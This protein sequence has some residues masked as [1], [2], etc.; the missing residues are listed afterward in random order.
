MKTNNID[1]H[2]A[3]E[4]EIRYRQFKNKITPTP[5]LFCSKH[6][7]FLDW[8]KDSKATELIQDGVKVAPYTPRKKSKKNAKKT[9]YYQMA[10]LSKIRADKRLTKSPNDAT[11]TQ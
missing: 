6:D 3:C 11:I 7:V 2:D 1:A 5:G 4:C 8:L 10:K 9:K